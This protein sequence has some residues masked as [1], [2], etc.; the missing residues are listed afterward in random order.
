M[1]DKKEEEK[2]CRARKIFSSFMTHQ[3]EQ[4]LERK[5]LPLFSPKNKYKK[6]IWLSGLKGTYIFPFFGIYV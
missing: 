2:A 5:N 4:N 1:M 3:R 6:F